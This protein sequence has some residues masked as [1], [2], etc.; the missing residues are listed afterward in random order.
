MAITSSAGT[1]NLC[2]TAQNVSPCG[3]AFSTS[4]PD[5]RMAMK[6]H[7]EQLNV[8]IKFLFIRR[9]CKGH[10]LVAAVDRGDQI[11]RTAKWLNQTQISC[12]EDAANPLDPPTCCLCIKFG[13]QRSYQRFGP[14]ADLR[15]ELIPSYA[16][17]EFTER[18]SPRK[19][20]ELVAIHEGAI[21]VEYHRSG[22]TQRIH[23]CNSIV[24][25][26]N[27]REA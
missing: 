12:L 17:R 11:V 16:R 8:M 20:M 5:T 19:H 24:A 26:C 15:A 13:Q 1:C 22:G 9:R 4:S 23:S 2:N 18:F 6:R 10:L 7:V 14:L 27:A 3:F 25:L 21:Q